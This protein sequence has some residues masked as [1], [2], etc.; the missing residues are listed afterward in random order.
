MRHALIWPLAALAVLSISVAAAATAPREV[1]TQM[2]AAPDSGTA[3]GAVI[4]SDPPPDT[5][6]PDDSAAPDATAPADDGSPPVTPMEIPVVEYDLSKLPKPVARLREQIIA[7]ATT[8]DIEKL[9]PIIEA[10]GEPPDFGPSDAGDPIGVLKLQSGDAD[11]REILAILI[12]VL[13]AGYVHV[14]VGTPDEAYLWP[15]FARYPIDKLSPPQL[16]ELFKLVFAGDYEDMLSNGVYDYFRAGISP[17]GTWL[18][19]N[20][21]D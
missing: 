13:D 14:D 18:Y 5:A 2:V 1:K 4:P 19:F 15:Y 7:A 20:S 12:E 11:G 21:G 10:N 17:N 3:T 16:V 9:R 8:G 6:A